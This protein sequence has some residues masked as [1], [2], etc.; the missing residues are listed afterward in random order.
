MANS[1][2][3]FIIRESWEVTQKPFIKTSFGYLQEALL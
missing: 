3:L 2:E 1:H